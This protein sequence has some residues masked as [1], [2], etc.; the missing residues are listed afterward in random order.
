MGNMQDRKQ[1]NF[2]STWSL[3]FQLFT[4]A[5]TQ[6]FHNALHHYFYY[7]DAT[8]ETSENEN[9]VS[10]LMVSKCR[11]S[12]LMSMCSVCSKIGCCCNFET[13][14]AQHLWKIAISHI[15]SK[16]NQRHMRGRKHS[17]KH[18]LW[19]SIIVPRLKNGFYS[20]LSVLHSCSAQ[21]LNLAS[22]QTLGTA[23]CLW[24]VERYDGPVQKVMISLSVQFYSQTI[25]CWF[26]AENGHQLKSNQLGWKCLF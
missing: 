22:Q 3:H 9:E 24:V 4:A 15:L 20:K 2:V 25:I 23:R 21:T 11:D 5:G 10:E 26:L 8:R 12:S 1:T 13:S 6:H 14:L 7:Q 18:H 16:P 19:L 17:V